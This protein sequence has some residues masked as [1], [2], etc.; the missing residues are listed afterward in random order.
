MEANCPYKVF[1]VM[2]LSDNVITSKTTAS[3]PLFFLFFRCYCQK[4]EFSG[5]PIVEIPVPFQVGRG[6]ITAS[7]QVN[8]LRFFP[9]VKTGW[10]TAACTKDIPGMTAMALPMFFPVRMPAT[11]WA[12]DL[13][14]NLFHVKMIFRLCL[15]GYRAV[16]ST[17]TNDFLSFHYEGS[18]K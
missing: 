17:K 7:A 9:V 16:F 18:Q 6:S 2:V 10:T 5:Q 14:V 12:A 4:G 13:V 1:S 8:T 15:F 3:P 11:A